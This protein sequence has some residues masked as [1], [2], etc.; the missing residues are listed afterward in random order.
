MSK[1]EDSRRP[2]R[3]PED[4]TELRLEQSRRLAEA[5]LAEVR[6][7]VVEEAGRVPR[8]ATLVL[9]GLAAAVGFALAFRGRRR[10]APGR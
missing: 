1:P 3:P 5:R 4:D 8:N 2:P 6:E 9:A 7:A 10:R